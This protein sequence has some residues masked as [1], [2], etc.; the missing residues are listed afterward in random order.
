MSLTRKTVRSAVWL[1][2]SRAWTQVMNLT[3]GVTLARLLSPAD[4][5]LLGMVLVTTGLVGVLA[6]LGL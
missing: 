6:D 4:Y 3:I 2:G 5:G 1:L